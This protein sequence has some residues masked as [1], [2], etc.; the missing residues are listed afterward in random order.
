M[1]GAPQFREILPD[2]WT[3]HYDEEFKMNYYHNKSEEK[4]LWEPPPGTQKV[5]IHAGDT[6][7]DIRGGERGGAPAGRGGGGYGGDG[8]GAG[9]ERGGRNER[10]PPAGYGDNGGG[11]AHGSDGGRRS[12]AE[13]SW[14]VRVDNLNWKT[15]STDLKNYFGAVGRVLRAEVMMMPNGKSEGFG[16]VE[17][18][19]REMAEAAMHKLHETQLDGRRVSVRPDKGDGR[20]PE[21]RPVGG[22]AGGGGGRGDPRYGGNGG[23]GGGGGGGDPRSRSRSPL[24]PG[25]GPPGDGD[26]VVHLRGMPWKATPRDIATFFGDLRVAPNGVHIVLNAEGRPS[27]D[28]FVEF[29]TMADAVQALQKH[30]KYLGPRFV[31]VYATTLREMHAKLEPIGGGPPGGP[32][33][34]GRGAGGRHS[35][36][37]GGP[38][39]PGGDYGGRGGGGF[40][41]GPP[42][43]DFDRGGPPPGWDRG[44]PGPGP[45]YDRRG[46]PMD[47]DFDARDDRKRFRGGPGPGEPPPGDRGGGGGGFRR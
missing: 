11:S 33:P 15:T 9:G 19:S 43:R 34:M 32:P 28:G 1:S 7:D 35:P 8:R 38:G 39:G 42:P 41:D 10:G 22:G 36:D 31:E 26:P 46:P 30:K 29:E 3:S 45:G 47:R 24:N 18:E 2:G 4:S 13:P 12:P 23:G 40:R 37:R 14:P 44:G 5:P 21:R 17:Y 20:P 27:G 16:I 6:P 25:A